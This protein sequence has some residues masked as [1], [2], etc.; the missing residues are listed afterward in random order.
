[1]YMIVCMCGLAGAKAHT[2]RLEGNENFHASS[3]SFHHQ[4][5]PETILCGSASK[6]LPWPPDWLFFF[7]LGSEDQ[8]Q[9]LLLKALY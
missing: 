3:L 6:P 2:R 8:T 9:F 7:L 5:S 1:M 4:G